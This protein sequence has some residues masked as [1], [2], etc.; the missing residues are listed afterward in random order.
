MSSRPKWYGDLGMYWHL[1]HC[2]WSWSPKRPHILLCEDAEI[3]GLIYILFGRIPFWSHAKL[4]VTCWLVIPY[5]SGAAYVYEHYVRPFFL[6]PQSIN[7]WHV[8]RK[9]DI[10]SKPD[11]ILTA[12]EKYMQE[13]GPEAFENLI[14]K[15]CLIT[16]I[17]FF[18]PTCPSTWELLLSITCWAGENTSVHWLHWLTIAVITKRITN[19]L[20]PWLAEQFLCENSFFTI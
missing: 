11:D 4:I 12:A 13:N 16:M 10:F 2:H 20:N 5:F 15:V 18:S 8:P 19:R 3:S 6:N 17:F 7:I 14:S 9:E 1:R